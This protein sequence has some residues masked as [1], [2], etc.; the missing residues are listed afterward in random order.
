MQVMVQVRVYVHV[1]VHL[2]VY[3]RLSFALSMF[4]LLFFCFFSSFFSFL[5][6]PFPTG[7]LGSSLDTALSSHVL[8]PFLRLIPRLMMI[9]MTN[10][11][12]CCYGYRFGI[13]TMNHRRTGVVR[14][15]SCC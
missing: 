14:G 13:L 5:S 12:G 11:Q 2:T 15:F 6:R 3:T 1:H 7:F 8:S 10:D 9:S 4:F